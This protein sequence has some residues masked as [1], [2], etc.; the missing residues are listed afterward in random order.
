MDMMDMV[1]LGIVLVI[2]I[3]AGWVINGAR[4]TSAGTKTGGQMPPEKP[5][6]PRAE[7]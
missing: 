5:K 4:R 3:G 6:G 1:V 2:G 7:E